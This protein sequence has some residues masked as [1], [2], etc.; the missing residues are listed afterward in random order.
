M[1]KKLKAFWR[2]IKLQQRLKAELK[3]AY[4]HKTTEEILYL[5]RLAEQILPP[6]EKFKSRIVK[7][8]LEMLKLKKLI[9]EDEFDKLPLKTRQE[10]RKS[11]ELSKHQLEESLGFVKPPT[12]I[13]Q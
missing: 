13:I 1:F 4:F 11:L 6:D 2:Q 5:T 12:K 8:R 7:I 3:P 9:A 10:L